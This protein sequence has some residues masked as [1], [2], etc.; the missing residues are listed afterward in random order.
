MFPGRIGVALGDSRHTIKPYFD[1]KNVRCNIISI[2]G[3]HSYDGVSSDLRL[4]GPHL[5][6]NGLVLLDDCVRN[7]TILGAKFPAEI[8]KAFSEHLTAHPQRLQPM[9]RVENHL[10][11]RHGGSRGF[12]VAAGPKLP[13]RTRR[14]L[15]NFIEHAS[16]LHELELESAV[17]PA[18][19]ALFALPSEH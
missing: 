16:P 12:C 7:E 17:A 10:G 3:E 19:A 5:P 9:M 11:P 4:L 14:W 18:A 6:E 8:Y 15:N 2:D 1:E 13:R